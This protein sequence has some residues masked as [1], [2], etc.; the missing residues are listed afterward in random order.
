MR[1]K[2]KALQALAESRNTL[3]GNLPW[4]AAWDLYFG[5]GMFQEALQLKRLWSDSCAAELNELAPELAQLQALCWLGEYD[6]VEAL[7]D[8]AP[9]QGSLK[10]LLPYLR[11]NIAVLQGH[12][13][14]ERFA[15]RDDFAALVAGKQILLQGP[16]AAGTEADTPPHDLRVV[17][18]WMGEGQAPDIAYYSKENFIPNQA[19]IE[20]LLA[21]GQLKFAVVNGFNPARLARPV[22]ADVA[23]RVLA[24]SP[25]LLGFH[26]PLLGVP[27]CL[28][29]MLSAGAA[30]VHVT[31]ADFYT[32]FPYHDDRYQTRLTE[33]EQFL[34]SWAAHDLSFNYSFVKQL[35][36][37]GR[38]TGDHCFTA[39]LETGVEDY[40]EKLYGRLPK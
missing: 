8:T 40:F 35:M 25:F 7:L 5:R 31:R 22:A 33:I 39:A 28:Y 3:D 17:F 21:S 13:T 19:E 18:N 15:G 24:P 6:R 10:K 27:R 29:D 2:L 9:A 32:R 38:V 11:Q 20:A 16:G 37:G 36:T 34:Y 12:S 14:V 4:L 23:G 26:A 1:F 30:A